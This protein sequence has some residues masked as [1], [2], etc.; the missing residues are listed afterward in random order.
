MTFRYRL[1][2]LFFMALICCC[3]TGLVYLMNLS[4]QKLSMPTFFNS[5]LNVA[6]Q[7]KFTIQLKPNETFSKDKAANVFKIAFGINSGAN[8]VTQRQFAT[9]TEAQLKDLLSQNC[10]ASISKYDISID[11]KLLSIHQYKTYQAEKFIKA[12]ANPFP[13]Q[14]VSPT[15]TPFD[16]SCFKFYNFKKIVNLFHID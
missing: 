1:F 8:N 7:T 14:N 2:R 11:G 4:F 12:H 16:V 15:L 6:F 9:I 5:R 3:L 10:S 13:K